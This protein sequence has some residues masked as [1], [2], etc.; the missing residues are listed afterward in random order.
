MPIRRLGARL[1]SQITAGEVVERPASVLKELIE[2]SLDAGARKLQVQIEEGGRKR[3]AVTDDGCGI[4]RQELALAL[5]R[6]ATSKLSDMDDFGQLQTL[7]FRGEALPS[8]AT[9]ARLE[10]VS[11]PPG[12]DHGYRLEG[13]RPGV[14]PQIHPHPAGTTVDVRDLFYNTP[15][16]RKFLRAPATEWKHVCAVLRAQALAYPEVTF[17]VSHNGRRV[18]HYPAVGSGVSDAQRLE[19]IL[20]RE[21]VEQSTP[22]EKR[23]DGMRL[24]GWA[25]M[26]TFSRSQPDLQYFFVNR[27]AVRD[28]TAAHAVRQGYADVLYGGR[29]PC[30][31]LYLEMSPQAVDVNVHPT[32]A[33]VR[34][35][36]A[37][38]VHR[39]L[40]QGVAGE[41]AGLRPA[42]A[43]HDTDH[44][45]R[46]VNENPQARAARLVGAGQSAMPLRARRD[47]EAL[48]TLEEVGEDAPGPKVL[49][50]LGLAR[51]QLH[52]IYI[53]AENE[54]GLVL[55]DMHAAHERI[56][57]ER[58]KATAATGI[59][60]QPL[61]VPQELELGPEEMA[62]VEES[63]ELL[64]ELGLEVDVA[65]P[66][67]V[68][69]RSLPSLLARAD[70]V[71]LLR[72]VLADLIV[73]GG[74]ERVREQENELL[75][76]MACHSAARAGRRLSLAEMDALLRD[77][78]E[79]ERSGQCNHG[80]PTWVQ[81]S[82]DQLD[83][84][85]L[86]GR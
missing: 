71:Q 1:I 53:L 57:Y 8:I 14:R 25:G 76:V 75:S 31:V 74:S 38:S 11:A 67:R 43:G 81:L 50:P 51:A 13:D 39:L 59:R 37:R 63:R 35:H 30:Y 18:L 36:D 47:D 45:R 40:S 23:T 86:R 24:Y 66:D 55:V 17:E 78:E 70:A 16:R 5:E 22:L 85:F 29:H 2:N 26:P 12:A 9:V 73:R 48:A 3:I 21:F 20:G 52:D 28:R 54:Q 10:L 68:C 82:I 32:K 69:I 80:R 83:K 41:I 34:F 42:D 60:V 7:G 6:H 56:T 15:P 49:P 79:V 4:P 19:S 58:L 33:E 46:L 27:R 62:C 77:M 72:D 84:L 65:G 44:F 61:L 64:R